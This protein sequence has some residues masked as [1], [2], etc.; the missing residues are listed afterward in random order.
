MSIIREAIDGRTLSTDYFQE[1]VGTRKFYV[2]NCPSV[3]AAKLA[4][5][6]DAGARV[7]PDESRLELYSINV[8]SDA[9]GA[10]YIVEATYKLLRLSDYFRAGW[11]DAKV[12]VSLPLVKPAYITPASGNTE[13]KEL[14]LGHES[15][16]H[17]EYRPRRT[18]SVDYM[19][20]QP[21]EGGGQTSVFDFDAISRERGRLHLIFGRLH[22]FIGGSVTQ[23]ERDQRRFRITYEWELDTGTPKPSAPIIINVPP[24]EEQSIDAILEPQTLPGSEPSGNWREPYSV[25]FIYSLDPKTRPIHVPYYPFVLDEDGW[26][27]LPGMEAW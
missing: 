9:G 25:P 16:E 15:I 2:L 24:P 4:F 19:T 6:A 20:E 14:V 7:F 1:R 10:R 3:A 12:Q 22:Q 5:D 23:D 13:Q 26:R 18:F 17:T 21:N 8:T 11:S 27:N